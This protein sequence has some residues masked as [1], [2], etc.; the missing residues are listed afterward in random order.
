[1]FGILRDKL[2]LSEDSSHFQKYNTH[3]AD[4]GRNKDKSPSID[5]K[6]TMPITTS[7]LRS[8]IDEGHCEQPPFGRGTEKTLVDL[9][10]K[11]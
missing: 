8:L 7:T 6:I 2:F 5:K 10:T 4:K 9:G 1:M 11:R 3:F